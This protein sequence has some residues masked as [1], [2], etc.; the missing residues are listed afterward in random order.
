MGSSFSTRHHSW[1]F[2]TSDPTLIFSTEQ[3]LKQCTSYPCPSC[4]VISRSK[5]VFWLLPAG[6]HSALCPAPFPWWLCLCILFPFP[7]CL[8]ILFLFPWCL[9]ILPHSH[10]AF[11]SCSYSY[12]PFASC[13]CSYDVFA[14]CSHFYDATASCSPTLP[15][16]N[17]RET[18]RN[19][20]TIQTS[21]CSFLFHLFLLIH[22]SKSN[23]KEHSLKEDKLNRI[24]MADSKK[25]RTMTASRKL[26][27]I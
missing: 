1:P 25:S 10:G 13:S 3:I 23:C 15:S 11:L 7:W 8:C 20:T 24:N 27:P 6:F 14:F 18:G 12:G 2:L 17:G 9:W 19:P 22:P 5:R 26:Y 21:W 4:L 16:P